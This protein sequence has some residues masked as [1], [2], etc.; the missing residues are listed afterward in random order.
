MGYAAFTPR[1]RRGR[2]IQSRDATEFGGEGN[3]DEMAV[4]LNI[5]AATTFYHHGRR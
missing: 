2:Y 3:E 5:M 1:R 4:T